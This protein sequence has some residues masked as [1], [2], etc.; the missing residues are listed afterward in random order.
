[1]YPHNNLF[2]SNILEIISEISRQ[3][4]E[5]LKEVFLEDL[6]LKERIEEYND[7]KKESL[8]GHVQ[9]IKSILIQ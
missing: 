2:H 8:V 3:K 4:N 5:Y 6:K 7:S 1:M 9:L